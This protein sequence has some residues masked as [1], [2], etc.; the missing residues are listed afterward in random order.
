MPAERLLLMNLS[1]NF[2]WIISHTFVKYLTGS[3]I[4]WNNLRLLNRKTKLFRNQTI[5]ET[6]EVLHNAILLVVQYYLLIYEI[7]KIFYFAETSGPGLMIFEVTEHT[8]ITVS[9]C[10]C[11]FQFVDLFERSVLDLMGMYF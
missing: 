8:R 11:K 5:F 6:T 3:T 9:E 10:C 2:S 7:E 1:E 4:Y